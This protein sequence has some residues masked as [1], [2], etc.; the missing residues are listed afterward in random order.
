MPPLIA[1]AGAV[2]GIA[3]LRFVI[4]GVRKIN[5]ELDELR[6]R[7]LSQEASNAGAPTLRKNAASGAYRLD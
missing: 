2:G 6:A 7:R 3:A 4:K 1:I 5:S